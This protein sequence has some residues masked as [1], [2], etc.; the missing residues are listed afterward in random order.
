[1]SKLYLKPNRNTDIQIICKLCSWG[2]CQTVNRDFAIFV[3]EQT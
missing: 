3:F 1:M 2:L